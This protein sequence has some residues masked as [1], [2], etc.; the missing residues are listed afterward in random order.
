MD[1]LRTKLPY[2]ATLALGLCLVSPPPPQ[3]ATARDDQEK[4]SQSAS[5]HPP[6]AGLR[7]EGTGIGNTAPYSEAAS[8]RPSARQ[9]SHW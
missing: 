8:I 3:E 9:Y 7:T 4:I 1:S 6:H 5:M 2:W